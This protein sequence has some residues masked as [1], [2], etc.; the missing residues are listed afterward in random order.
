MA[1]NTRHLLSL[2]ALCGTFAALPASATC[3]SD[4][5]I[6]S[7]C[8]TAASYCPREYADAA[9]Q[10][11]AIAQNQALFALVG[12]LYGGDGRTTFGLPDLRGRSPVGIFQGPGLADISQGE[13]GGRE[14]L[15]LGV[16]QMPAHS[17]GAVLRGTAATG[18]TDNPSG[19]VPARLPRSNIYSSAG[20]ND[21]QMGSSSVT[22]ATTGGGQPVDIRNPYVGLRYCIA[23]TGLFPPRN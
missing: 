16:N 5:Y 14:T 10:L 9:G 7:I 21:A 15:S 6:G 4:P 11:L 22:V 23:L 12:T 1:R 18:N 19:A 2:A 8:I 20:G 17:H 3:T 13:S